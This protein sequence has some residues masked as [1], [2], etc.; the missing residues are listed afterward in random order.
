[1]RGLKSALQHASHVHAWLMSLEAGYQPL[2][3]SLA[4]RRCPLLN[5]TR[6][7]RHT[8][9]RNGR[10]HYLLPAPPK[11]PHSAG[12]SKHP[13]SLVRY[14]STTAVGT[15]GAPTTASQALP[16]LSRNRVNNRLTAAI[17]SKLGESVS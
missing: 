17:G 13:V 6:Q 9:N 12:G 3:S 2:M 8:P 10:L 4:I 5:W 7:N 1:M 15:V 16:L 11:C 14:E